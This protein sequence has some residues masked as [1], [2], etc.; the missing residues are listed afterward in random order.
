MI[1]PAEETR[2][3]VPTFEELPRTTREALAGYIEARHRPGHFLV[4][5]LSNDLIGA[6]NRGDRD[7]L[8][9]LTEIVRWLAWYAPAICWGSRKAVDAW[10]ARIEEEA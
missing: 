5:V 3:R 7:S 9:A 2:Y 1:P 10:L 6:V 4:A 8:A